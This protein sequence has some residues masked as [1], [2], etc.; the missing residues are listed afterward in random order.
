LNVLV[1]QRR[2]VAVG[3]LVAAVVLGAASV[4]WGVWGFARNS[5]GASATN[6]SGKLSPEDVAKDKEE[7]SADEAAKHSPDYQIAAVWAGAVALLSLLAAGWVYTQPA[8]PAAPLTTARVETLIFG[9]AVGFITAM[10]GAF[11]GYRW[12]QSLVMWV[13]GGDSREAKWVLYAFAIFLAGLL[14]MFLSLQL[15]SSEQRKNAALRRALYGFNAVFVGILLLLVLAAL[16]VVSF[17]KV[18][19]TL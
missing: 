6:S 9:G 10:A 12:H 5:E 8:D 11:L 18:P 1:T 3:L 15:A 17:L 19:T 4:W 14:I 13:G 7:A 16:N 2:Q